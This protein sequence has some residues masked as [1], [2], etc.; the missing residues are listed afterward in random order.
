MGR[1]SNVLRDAEGPGKKYLVFICPGCNDFHMVCIEPGPWKWDGNADSPTF[2]PSILI[3]NGHFASH[4]KHG[5]DR[6]WCD[7]NRELVEEG[8]PPSKYKCVVC[9]SFVRNG[10][11]EF[12]AD[13]TH[14]LAGQTVDLP[15]LPED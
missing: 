9:H 4:F 15:I 11:I 7:Y 14:E 6:C 5:E 10:R 3:R 2:T 12:L 1:L 13:C 8:K